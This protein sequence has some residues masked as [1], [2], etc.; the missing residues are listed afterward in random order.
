MARSAPLTPISAGMPSERAMIAACEVGS[1]R[2]VTMPR[3]RAGSRAA[4]SEGSI[5]AATRMPSA[6]SAG[7]GVP[8]PARC[9]MM[10][11]PMSRMSAA[12]SRR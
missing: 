11:R 4:M 9:A 1:P 10:R 5:S 7:S 8:R 6:V 12:R 2:S 3:T